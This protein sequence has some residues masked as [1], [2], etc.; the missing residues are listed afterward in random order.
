MYKNK[1]SKKSVTYYYSTFRIGE[2]KEIFKAR[3]RIFTSLEKKPCTPDISRV[4]FTIFLSF[5]NKV[6]KI[7]GVGVAYFPDWYF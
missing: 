2:I 5:L 7:S 1:M 4:E 6:I 3:R